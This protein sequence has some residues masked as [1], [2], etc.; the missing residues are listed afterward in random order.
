[1]ERERWG[2]RSYF[3]FA[4]LGSAVGL[5]KLWRFPGGLSWCFSR[6]KRTKWED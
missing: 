6:W 2:T 3:I 1:M 4:A 5:G